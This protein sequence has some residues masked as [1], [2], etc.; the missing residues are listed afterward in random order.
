M[1]WVAA[2]ATVLMSVGSVFAE[3]AVKTG[4]ALTLEEAE[5]EVRLEPDYLSL[6]DVTS[7][8]PPVAAALAKHK[9][10]GLSLP[11]LKSLTPE[12]AAALCT[13]RGELT[14]DGLE[15]LSVETAQA[16]AKHESRLSLKGISSL[17]DDAAL[18]LAEHNGGLCMG[19]LRELRCEPLARRLLLTDNGFDV[20]GDGGIDPDSLTA[21]SP[22]VAELL[23]IKQQD[24]QDDG[25]LRL[26]ALKSPPM[27]VLRV[28]AQLNGE[29]HLGVESVTSETVPVLVTQ[30]GYLWLS[31]GD[32]DIVDKA[33]LKT[34]LTKASGLSLSLSSISRDTA[35]LLARFRGG[36][37]L[38]N[39][40]LPEDMERLLA[41]SEA[42]RLVMPNLKEIKTGA[43]AKK[44]VE[45]RTTNVPSDFVGMGVSGAGPGWNLAV[46]DVSLPVAER[47]KQFQGILMLRNLKRISA[48][49]ADALAE[50][51]SELL[52]PAIQELNSGKLASKLAACSEDVAIPAGTSMFGQSMGLNL[53]H[54]TDISPDAAESLASHKGAYLLLNGITSLSDDAAAGLAQFSG[55]L[56]LARV[57]TLSAE[58]QR[59]LGEGKVKLVGLASLDALTDHRLATKIVE[60]GGLK[61]V[62]AEV[63]AVLSKRSCEVR[64]GL[65]HGFGAGL[66]HLYLNLTHLTPDIAAALAAKKGDFNDELVLP[67]LETIDADSASELAKCGVPLHLPGFKQLTPET[68]AA[69]AE[70]TGWIYLDGV[71]EIPVEIAKVLANKKEGY[72]SF[73]P[74]Y[75]NK[76]K[77]TLKLPNESAELLKGNKYIKL[78][79]Q[80]QP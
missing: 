14:L 37:I 76:R 34:L 62:T 3:D 64:G 23:V 47:L 70:K 40:T 63:A 4:K 75:G 8:T 28:L 13:Y 78:P 55:N 33:A 53:S 1:R 46:E 42:E 66:N 57:R 5:A 36:L 24:W 25:G 10:D 48:D 22:G 21:I 68:A 16:L 38:D 20:G 61:T 11:D 26:T 80:L 12:T 50:C 49:V 60:V 29:L 7:I 30:R 54:V 19:G 59:L 6:K 9:G 35:T 73:T 51:K 15:Q 27:D 41:E 58:A 79:K 2:I 39:E 72:I 17:P 43:L 31:G 69:F 65:V 77:T 74:N 52:M 32:K 18:A 45:S 67:A 71:E 56:S 44:L